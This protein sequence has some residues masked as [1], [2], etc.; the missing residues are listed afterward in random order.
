[1]CQHLRPVVGDMRVE[2]EWVRWRTLLASTS[3]TAREF[4]SCW[5]ELQGEATEM[6]AYLGEELEGQLAI[7]LEGWGRGGW[8]GTPGT[9]S[10]SR[11][12]P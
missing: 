7:P 12:G 9:L 3:C 10:P 6:A 2:E 8:M 11:G 4:A 1:M 5:E